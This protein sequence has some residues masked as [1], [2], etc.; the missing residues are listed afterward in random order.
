MN[1]KAFG[2]LI[3]HQLAK[4]EAHILEISKPPLVLNYL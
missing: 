1:E 3:A 2:Y 4:F